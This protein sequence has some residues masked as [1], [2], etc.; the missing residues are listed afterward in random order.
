M[1]FR[2]TDVALIVGVTLIAAPILLEW[3]L[4]IGWYLGALLGVVLVSIAGYD[5]QARMLKMGTPGEDLLDRLWEKLR[6][7]YG[8]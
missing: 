3:K 4:G 8:K 6:K 7:K 5:A 1:N 2:K